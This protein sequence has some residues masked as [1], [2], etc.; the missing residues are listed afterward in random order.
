MVTL[1]HIHCSFYHS[2]ITYLHEDIIIMLS[3]LNLNAYMIE[4]DVF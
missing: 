1:R 4:G 2:N 3:N